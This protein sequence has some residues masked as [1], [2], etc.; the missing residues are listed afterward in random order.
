MTIV[1]DDVE[2][3]W[4]FQ[5]DLG[6]R[7]CDQIH[8]VLGL[9]FTNPP[10]PT[11]RT[12]PVDHNEGI[13][14]RWDDRMMKGG[15]FDIRF[16]KDTY[17]AFFVYSHLDTVEFEINQDSTVDEVQAF[18]TALRLVN[19]EPALK[20]SSLDPDQ[21]VEYGL[22]DSYVVFRTVEEQDEA[23]QEIDAAEAQL[24]MWLAAKTRANKPFG[25]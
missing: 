7:R 17:E 24:G 2:Y 8:A 11:D 19:R 18:F 5:T 6:V 23:E 15:F 22:D 12:L 21:V 4:M 16:N 3:P 9:T 1:L 25:S 20:R 13:C 10:A 14:Q